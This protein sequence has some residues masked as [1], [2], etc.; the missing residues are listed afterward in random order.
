MERWDEWPQVHAELQRAY[1]SYSKLIH[2]VL[3]SDQWSPLA[4]SMSA[5][6]TRVR[7]TVAVPVFLVDTAKYFNVAMDLGVSATPA[8]VFFHHG[9]PVRIQRCGWEQD[10]K[11][12]F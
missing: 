5:L 10:T 3:F 2:V 6:V 11:C 7:S 9:K 4:G 12:E 1:F 8:L